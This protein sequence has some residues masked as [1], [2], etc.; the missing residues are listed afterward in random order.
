M[1]FRSY[2][3]SSMVVSFAMIGIIEGV[4]VKTY[5]ASLDDEAEDVKE[6][7]AEYEGEDE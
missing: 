7:N 6:E 1:P 4:A 2:G 5:R 3:G